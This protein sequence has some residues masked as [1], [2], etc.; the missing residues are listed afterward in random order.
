MVDFNSIK[1]AIVKNINRN[2]ILIAVAV[3]GIAVTGGLIYFNSNPGFSFPAIF[4]APDSQIAKAAID[5]IN[6]N[7]L[8]SSPASLVSAAEESGLVKMKIKI[9]TTEFDSYATKDGKLL[10]PQAFNMGP[11]P[12]DTSASP[13]A[14]AQT[15]EQII[16]AIQ[17]SDKPTLE[18]FIVSRCPFGL[19]MQRMIAEAVKNVP[20]LAQYVKVEYF[21]S[22]SADGKSITSMHD[23]QTPEG[24]ENLRQ[25]C[26]R[27]E[28]PAKYWNYVSCQMKAS[29]TENSCEAS[30]GVNSAA[31]N[32]CV[33]DPVRGVAYAKK[34][35][36]AADKYGVSGSPTL[37]LNG[38]T[39]AEFTSDNQP[40]FGSAR[41][42]DEIK[43]IVCDASNTQPGFCSTK[44]NPAQA[45]TSFSQ[46]YTT[47][48][49]AAN[50]GNSGATGANCAPAK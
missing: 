29:G 20:S 12:A 47:A 38:A 26:I 8:A 16:A 14:S 5:Y 42:S 3:I 13:A 25:I 2:N 30:T 50:S 46:T 40:V 48:S 21:G 10:F 19:Q 17:K 32:A 49:S 4:G 43:T 7:N 44:L 35:F 39:I 28:Q 41:S 18:A 6:N 9:G 24:K 1:N 45:D 37:I 31:L 11:K 36:A 27:E 15:A 23:S 22:V 33:S 34:D